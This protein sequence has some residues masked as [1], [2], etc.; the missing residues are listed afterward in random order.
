MTNWSFYIEEFINYLTLERGLS[1]NS[2]EAY[3]RDVLKLQQFS[4]KDSP[5]QIDSN[6]ISRI[7]E[8][9]YDLGI[10]ATSQARILSGWKSFFKFLQLEEHISK[11]PSA[12]IESPKTRRKL[13]EVLHYHEIESMLEAIDHSS[14]EGTRNRAILETMY[15]CGLRV[16][17]LTSLKLSDCHFHEGYI[18]VTGKR[19]KT[20]LVPIGK[21]AVKYI[22]IYEQT[23]RNHQE[24][25]PEAEDILFLNRR[26]NKLTRVMIY[27]IVKDLAL[28]AGIAKEVSP[29]TFRHSFATHLIEGG[30][31]LRAVQEMLGHVSI[32]TTEIYTHL[33]RAYLQQTI[34]QFHP[35]A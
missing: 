8:E 24:A 17:E 33:D 30:A 29:H 31:D 4:G 20:R 6:D 18:Q 35:R 15:S 23:I 12:L 3:Q 13:P 32:T 21:Q 2:S 16:S 27:I 9:L 1:E 34:Q 11:D 5:K 26:G 25:K 22:N 14:N 19:D 28:K 7:L 10:A